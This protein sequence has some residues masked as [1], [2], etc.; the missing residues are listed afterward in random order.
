MTQIW[1]SK[2]PYPFVADTLVLAV[3]H[4]K[5]LADLLLWFG[6]RLVL[7]FRGHWACLA[8]LVPCLLRPCRSLLDLFQVYVV[9]FCQTVL[10]LLLGCHVQHVRVVPDLGSET[11]VTE[12]LTHKWKMGCLVY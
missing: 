12:G 11:T 3:H 6:R 2:D 4:G 1:V 9:V 8:H 7:L 5:D 10:L